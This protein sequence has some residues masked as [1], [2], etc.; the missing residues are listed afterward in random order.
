MTKTGTT[1]VANLNADLLDGQHGS[2]Y[3]SAGTWTPSYGGFSVNPTGAICRYV[4]V[5]KLCTAFVRMPNAGTSNATNFTVSIPFTAVTVAGMAWYGYG[6]YV[7]NGA[8]G[9]APCLVNIS[10][11]GSIATLYKDW[12]G[13]GWTAAGNKQA[14]FT[15]VYEVA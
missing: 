12:L 3:Y 11:G 2:Y 13:A 10:S 9:S 14:T 6:G 1:V 7:D 4:L 8:Q 5:G 15:I